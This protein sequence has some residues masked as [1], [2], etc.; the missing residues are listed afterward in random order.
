MSCGGG[1]GGGSQKHG[2]WAKHSLQVL[3]LIDVH[4]VSECHAGEPPSFTEMYEG[5]VCERQKGA[6]CT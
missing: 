3:T 1:D 2:S 5:C 4:F 6:L